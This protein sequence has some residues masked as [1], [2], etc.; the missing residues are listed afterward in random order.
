VATVNY[1]KQMKVYT[2]TETKEPH[3]FWRN[4]SSKDHIRIESY[5]TVDELNSYIG[6]RDQEMNAHYKE[7][8]SRNT[9]SFT[10]LELF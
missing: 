3:H 8:S 4:K 6:L 9:R 7:H 5:G 2:K 1:H 10:R